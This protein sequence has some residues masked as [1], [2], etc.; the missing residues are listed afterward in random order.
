MNG[1]IALVALTLIALTA[2]C[3]HAVAAGADGLPVGNVDAGP[4]GV[5]N[6]G[7]EMRYVT[8]PAGPN[9]V[10]AAVRREGGRVDRS[11]LLRGR[12]TVPAVA[13]DASPAGLSA[14]GSKLVLIRPRAHFPQKETTLAIVETGRLRRPEVVTLRGDFSFDAI[15]PSGGFMYLIEY[16]SR[17][18]PTRYQVRGYD[19][20]AG[21]LIPGAIVD[22]RA[23]GEGMRGYPITRASSPDGRW[24]YT[25]YDG[26]GKHPFVHAL[27]TQE[28][29]AACIDLDGLAGRNDLFELR[30]VVDAG[31][32]ELNVVDGTQPVAVIDAKTFRVSAPERDAGG[33]REGDAGT[34]AARLWIVGIAALLVTVMLTLVLRRRRRLAPTV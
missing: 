19:T 1:R 30:L 15:S 14:D 33:S 2:S 6:P 26:A 21:R 27:D 24:A 4:G 9:T 32:D 25:L 28:R 20:S 3:T 7:G 22:P 16:T 8:L 31:S 10:L 5:T 13:L 23:F 18:D 29:T 11:L 12:F 17:R 34:P